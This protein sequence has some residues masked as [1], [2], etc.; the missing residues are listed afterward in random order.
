METKTPCWIGVLWTYFLAPEISQTD[1]ST[2]I[3]ASGFLPPQYGYSHEDCTHKLILIEVE[4][5]FRKTNKQ[6]ENKKPS[7]I[8][9][10][11]R[12]TS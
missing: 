11:F 5:L 10:G 6:K 9:Q 4:P 2:D 8:L 7:S 12:E 1:S 3:L